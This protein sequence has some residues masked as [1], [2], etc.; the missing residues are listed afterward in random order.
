MTD[1]DFASWPDFVTVRVVKLKCAPAGFRVK[2]KYILTTVLDPNLISKDDLFELY[3]KRWQ[4]EIN[5][6][7]IKTTLG[8]DVLRGLKPEM[9]MKE[10]WAHWL[11]YNMIRDAICKA[12]AIKKV[13]PSCISFRG[14]QQILAHF[15]SACSMGLKMTTELWVDILKLIGTQTVGNRPDRF[16]PR[17][18]KRRKKNFALLNRPR[19]LARKCLH[20]K[21]K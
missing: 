19:H 1:E 3:R 21:W 5:L 15:R 14:A 4:A 9:V 7:S 8:M 6:R 20:K 18:I 11:A 10:I 2:T 17:A 12:A 13:L 16:E